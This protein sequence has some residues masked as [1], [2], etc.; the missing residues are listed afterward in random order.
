M[1]DRYRS[2]A[3]LVVI[4]IIAVIWVGALGYGVIK[5]VW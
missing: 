2:E 1:F 5:I 3:S 4:L